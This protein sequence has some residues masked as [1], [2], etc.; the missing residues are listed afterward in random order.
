MTWSKI[1]TRNG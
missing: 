1:K